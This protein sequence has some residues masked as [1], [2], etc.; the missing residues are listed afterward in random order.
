M[1]RRAVLVTVALGWL[2][3]A[4]VAVAAATGHVWQAEQGAAS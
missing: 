4:G 3:W 1:T 2:F